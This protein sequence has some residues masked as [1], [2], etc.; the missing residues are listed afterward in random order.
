MSVARLT[1]LGSSTQTDCSDSSITWQY[2]GR[3][4]PGSSCGIHDAYGIGKVSQYKVD[5]YSNESCNVYIDTS[6]LI[7]SD[8]IDFETDVLLNLKT[9]ASE[10]CFGQS[11]TSTKA[12]GTYTVGS[13]TVQV[14]VQGNSK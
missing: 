10:Q 12:V 6:C 7:S 14:A 11:S 13:Y 9:K 2:Q 3:A 5:L 4:S 1:S 8:T